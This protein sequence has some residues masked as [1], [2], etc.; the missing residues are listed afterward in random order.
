MN[1]RWYMGWLGWLFIG[2][3]MSMAQ[4]R[5][6]ITSSFPRNNA[7]NL[8]CNTFVTLSLTFPSESKQLDPATL[9]PMGI[10][11]YPAQDDNKKIPADLSYNSELHFIKIVPRQLLASQTEYVLEITRGLVD[12]RGFS[13][14]PFVLRFTT[15]V[16]APEDLVAARGEEEVESPKEAVAP[17]S[18]LATF[19]A[20]PAGDSMAIQWKTTREYMQ[21][22]F[23]I[24]RS[25]DGG[26][27]FILDRVPSK[28]DSKRSQNYEWVDHNPMPGWNH[29]R[30]S[31]INVLGEL[32]H[33]D[34]VS[35]FKQLIEFSEDEVPRNGDLSVRFIVPEKTTMAMILRSPK[36]EIVKRKAGVI[37]AGD[38]NQKISLGEVPPGNYLVIMR[39]PNL[40]VTHR[41]LIYP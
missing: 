33:S 9:T 24:D 32:N 41:I 20:F 11:L 10:L 30:L 35:V 5:A 18:E 1:Y 28:G 6:Y 38:H 26:D 34:T 13:L 2:L 7:N 37:Y 25:V 15:G 40:T 4:Q 31:I 23:T 36:G 8:Q 14:R 21:S 39:L 16:C 3:T 17:Y 27:F 12:D 19:T 22:D 29:Y